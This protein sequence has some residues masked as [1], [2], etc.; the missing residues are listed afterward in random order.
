MPNAA[1]LSSGLDTSR[2]RRRHAI[3]YVVRAPGRVVAYDASLGYYG[4]SAY[5]ADV[6]GLSEGRTPHRVVLVRNPR[7]KEVPNGNEQHR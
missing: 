7:E 4:P 2:L 1:P 6:R 5:R 3:Q